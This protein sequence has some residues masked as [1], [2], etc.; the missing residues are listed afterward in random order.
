MPFSLN[1]SEFIGRV[2]RDIELRHTRE[3]HAVATL[4]IATDRPAKAGG[5]P[6]TDWHS[7]VCWDKLAELASQYLSKGR[8]VFV[9]GRLQYRSWEDKDG[10]TR[11]NAEI[12]ASDLI[13]L[14]RKPEPDLRVVNGDEP[15]LPF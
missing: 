6:E 2:G 3:G 9:A 13:L 11:R 14:D 12:V 4:S 1:R 10:R 15:D 7:V 5:D 8:L